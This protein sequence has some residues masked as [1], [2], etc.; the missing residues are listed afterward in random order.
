[1][2]MMTG[3]VCELRPLLTAV[4]DTSANIYEI[5]PRASTDWLNSYCTTMLQNLCG[6]SVKC[7]INIILLA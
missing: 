2:D 1:M 3:V 7:H 6:H 4:A 5:F